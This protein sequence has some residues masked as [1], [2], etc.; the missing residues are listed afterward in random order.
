MVVVK[1]NTAWGVMASAVIFVA[2]YLV[3]WAARFIF[4]KK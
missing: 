3:F 1:D 4:M 2:C